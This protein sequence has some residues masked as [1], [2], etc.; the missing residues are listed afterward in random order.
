MA[1]TDVNMDEQGT[2]ADMALGNVSFSFASTWY[3]ET[4]CLVGEQKWRVY[5]V[6]SSRRQ[7]SS[8]KPPSQ[9]PEPCP[10]M[11]S[12]RAERLHSQSPTPGEIHNHRRQQE[13]SGIIALHSHS[14]LRREDHHRG[15]EGGF[16]PPGTRCS[17]SPPGQDTS[18]FAGVTPVF[19]HGR[20][21]GLQGLLLLF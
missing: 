6:A 10:T 7:G 14:S 15:D 2:G 4:Q 1:A 5:N 13:I 8:G 11:T 17:S 18:F 12:K 20:R 9:T 21:V 16:K 3:R 19:A